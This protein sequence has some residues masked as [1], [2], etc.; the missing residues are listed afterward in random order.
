MKK[1]FFLVVSL[2]MSV[3]VQARSMREIWTS[4]PDSLLPYVDRNHRLEMVEFIDMN[5]TGD[6]DNLFGGKSEMDTIT[7][8]YI[9]LTLSPS[10]TMQIKR[11][12]VEGG[13]SL[14]C[15]VKTYLGPA[16]ESKIQ[17]FH[18]DWSPAV[19]AF[20]LDSTEIGRLMPRLLVKPDTMSTEH[21]IYYK[22]LVSP[23]LVGVSLSPDSDLLSVRLSLP[24]PVRDERPALE[25]MTPSL[26]LRWDAVRRF[27]CIE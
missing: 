21:F 9:G 13:D 4:L 26:S 22:N 18:Q 10:S 19:V 27:F 2:I 1:M 6:V 7:A 24:M 5:L 15:L 17:F 23:C 3:T 8:D 14:L 16:A 11:L 12:P 25:A 20:S